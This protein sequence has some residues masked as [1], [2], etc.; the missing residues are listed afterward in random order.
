MHSINMNSC[1]GPHPLRR[2]SLLNSADELRRLAQEQTPLLGNVC[3]KGQTTVW[4]AKPNTG[5]T[6]ICMSEL[7]AAVQQGRLR[8]E[9]VYY[10]AADDNPAGVL[11]KIDEL[12]PYG[13]HVLAPGFL[14]FDP[15][16]LTK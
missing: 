1:Q 13:I 6:L 3:L 8:G 15:R 11:E 7:P 4:Y 10:V 14:E 2:F 12:Q 9:D 5:K 16:H